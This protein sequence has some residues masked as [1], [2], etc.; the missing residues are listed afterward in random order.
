MTHDYGDGH[1]GGG[2]RVT[3]LIDIAFRFAIASAQ[4]G[5]LGGVEEVGGAVAHQVEEVVLQVDVHQ[6]RLVDVHDVG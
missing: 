3:L 6:I 4:G 2:E 5:V 1:F